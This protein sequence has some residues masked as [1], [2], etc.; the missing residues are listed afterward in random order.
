MKDMTTLGRQ[1]SVRAKAVARAGLAAVLLLFGM[2]GVPM[3]FAQEFVPLPS[4]KRS[5]GLSVEET[6]QKR[7]SVRKY[8]KEPLTLGEVAQLLWAAQGQTGRD[9]HR[10]APSAGALYPLELTLVARGVRDLPAGV[11]RYEPKEHRL[12]RKSAMDVRD[13]LTAAALGQECAASAPA[14]FVFSAVCERTTGKYKERGKQYVSME[15]GAAGENLML[16]AESLS[17]GTVFVGAFDDD[18]VRTA[19]NLPEGED[20]LL[21]M[22]VGRK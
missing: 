20:P 21:I 9:G 4:P 3:V 10:T 17:L 5:G 22:P 7:R 13:E 12:L 6:L 19:L 8:G 18:H 15:A 2:G 14:V 1:R 11:Y 16:Q